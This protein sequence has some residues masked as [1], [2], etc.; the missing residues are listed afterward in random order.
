MSVDQILNKILTDAT[1]DAEILLQNAKNEAEARD[2]TIQEVAQRQ[3][4]ELEKKSK[5]RVTETERRRMLTA[6]LD[7]RKNTLARRRELLNQAFSKAL[8]AYV[9]LPEP[10]YLALVIK[11]IT[12]ASETGTEKVFVPAKDE[13][14]YTGEAPFLAAANAALVQAGKPGALSF[15]GVLPKL[16]GGVVLSGEIA[17]IDC[18]FESLIA[19]FRETQEMNVSNI[20]FEGEV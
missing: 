18:S 8:E 10:D 4:A 13:E 5:A 17:D 11:L 1:H 3:I 12:A 14:K 15:G 16:R 7:A 2:N 9:S 19:E 20:L 6:G